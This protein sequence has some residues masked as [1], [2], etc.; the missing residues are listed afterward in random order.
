MKFNW[1]V[2]V[3]VLILASCS[4]GKKPNE[5]PFVAQGENLMRYAKNVAVYDTEQGP[6]IAVRNP[7][8]TTA[9]LGQYLVEKPFESVVSFSST[10]WFCYLRLGEASRVKGILEGRYVHDSTMRSLL[11]SGAVADLGTEAAPDIERLIQLQPEVILYSPYFDGSQEN[12]KITG[13]IL[14]PYADYLENTPLGRAEWI[15]VLGIMAGKRQEADAWFAEIESRYL[16][17][18][19]LCVSVKHRPIVFSDL[20]FN[21]QW[22]VAGGQSYIAQLFA[23]AG[24]DYV[25]KDEPSAA[26]FPLDAETI[27]AKAQHAEVWRVTNS[28]PYPMTYASMASQNPIYPLFDA[29]KNRK[30]L[31]C[32]IQKTGYFE[33]S[34]TEPDVLLADFVY[35][36]HPECLV[37]VWTDY[38]PKYYHWLEE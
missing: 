29:F 32:D 38:Q 4:N 13:A 31:V 2:I 28:A 3:S 20:A 34:Q 6:L 36:F 25:W 5:T 23:D 27:L 12:L 7:W 19:D 16:K 11:D 22:Y 1:L 18:K 35:F 14:F 30:V 8:D 9:W 37:G 33:C 26:S 17:I 15:R 24:V 10:Q 21:G